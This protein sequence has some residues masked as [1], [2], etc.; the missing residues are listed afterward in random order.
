MDLAAPDVFAAVNDWHLVKKILGQ[1]YGGVGTALKINADVITALGADLEEKGNKKK[2]SGKKS[3][4][5]WV[6]LSIV[7]K[8]NNCAYRTSKVVP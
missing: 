8:I 1:V 6:G 5:V 3:V 4:H 7:T 2:N